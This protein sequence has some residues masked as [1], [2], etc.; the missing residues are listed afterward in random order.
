MD[1]SGLILR[2]FEEIQQSD[3]SYALIRMNIKNFRYYNA[4]YGRKAGNLILKEVLDLLQ[5]TLT[6]DDFVIR[7]YADNYLMFKSY[8]NKDALI[9]HWLYPCAV[10]YTHLDVYKRQVSNN[11]N[12]HSWYK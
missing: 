5:S 3:T 6:Q 10:S 1:N 12:C 2:K 9:E 11:R 7:E 8:E 4:K